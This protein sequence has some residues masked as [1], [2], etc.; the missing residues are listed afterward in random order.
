MAL[1]KKTAPAFEAPDA[2]VA[3]T[4]PV[5]ETLKAVAAVEAEVKT[6]TVV[7]TK[8]ETA[9]ETKTAA[10]AETKTVEAETKVE[11]AA[12]TETAVAVKP[13]TAV[14]TVVSKKFQASLQEYHNAIDPVGLD[15]NT[16]SR[17]TVGLD[18]FSDDKQIDL[19]KEIRLEL[20]SYN[21]RYVVSPGVDNDEAKA[22][23]R[24]SLDGVVIDS[25][26]DAGMLVADYLKNLKEVEGYKDASVKQYLNIVGFLTHA[27]DAEIIPEDRIIISLQ[28]PPQSRAVFSRH[29]I[30]MGVKV[31]QK[32]MAETNTLVCRQHKAVN[33]TTKYATIDF[34]HK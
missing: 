10:P 5:A 30:T 17:V 23:V 4:K 15:F 16:F 25:G 21:D 28:V 20:M 1:V 27:N 2:E 9:A 33:G 32:I 8:V 3:A 14:S 31:A 34:S 26:E 18:G 24:Y 7:E 19:G 29:Q 22:F 6:E 13:A 11:A 12:S